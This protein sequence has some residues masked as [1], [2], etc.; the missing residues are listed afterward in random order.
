MARSWSAFRRLSPPER[1]LV[2]AALVLLPLTSAALRL[3]GLRACQSASAVLVPTGPPLD[4]AD[5]AG[6]VQSASRMV[7]L[8]AVRGM[9]RPS[10]LP[11]SLVLWALL[12]RRQL[13]AHLRIGVRKER[14]VLDAHAWVEWRGFVVND[15]RGVRT[16]FVPFDIQQSGR[17]QPDTAATSA[18]T[19]RQPL[20]PVPRD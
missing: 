3:F 17:E 9:T 14:D 11:R 6:Y 20:S 15:R 4:E 1:R 12:R 8:A 16:R 18:R 5:A 19:I 7:R 2:V 13:D 10:C